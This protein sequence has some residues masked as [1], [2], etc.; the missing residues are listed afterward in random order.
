MRNNMSPARTEKDVSNFLELFPVLKEAD[1]S[2]K[3]EFSQT[4]RFQ[5]IPAQKIIYHTGDECKYFALVISGSIR[6][7][8]NTP[9]GNEATY[10]RV[11]KGECCVLTA[12]CLMNGTTFPAIARAEEDVQ[13]LIL[14]SSIVREW[15]HKHKVWSEYILSIISSKMTKIATTMNHLTFCTLNCRIASVLLEKSEK[16]STLKITHNEIALEIGS[17]REAVSRTLKE[18]EKK[19][20]IKMARN[21]IEILNP[22]GLK[23]ITTL[24]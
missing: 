1:S 2:A 5:N 21:T 14:P 11:K 18:F 16:S 9:T 20:L 6:V 10:Y 4:A 24:C 12:S 22:S 3:K 17:A 15:T 23:N 13:A 7:F 8:Y 19:E